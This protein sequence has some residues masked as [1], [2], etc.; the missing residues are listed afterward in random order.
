MLTS[1]REEPAAKTGNYR[2]DVRLERTVVTSVND[3]QSLKEIRI[4]PNPTRDV[5]YLQL[6]SQDQIRS[7]RYVL[8]D[9]LGR[10][11][12]A[13]SYTHA[14]ETL[15]LKGMPKGTYVVRIFRDNRFVRSEKI[16]HE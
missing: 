16:L 6:P 2:L 5:L 15:S 11:V 12:M 14:Q 13:G 1:T 8:T 4:F 3:P 9:V 10:G 7:W